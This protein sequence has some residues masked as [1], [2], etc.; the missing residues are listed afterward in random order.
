M[1]ATSGWR[2]TS[3]LV[4]RVTAMPL[5]RFNTRSASTSPLENAVEHGIRGVENGLITVT[6]TTIG[7][8]LILTV[9]DNGVGVKN[10]EPVAN[11][12]SM[13]IDITLGRL[14]MPGGR[15]DSLTIESPVS[16]TQSGT[17][18]SL[19]IPFKTYS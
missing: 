15:P 11:H 3:A 5:T 8:E 4:K 14:Q 17:R 18:V 2:T 10:V 1:R 16:E 13:A 7:K 12:R 19:A 6:F 9:T